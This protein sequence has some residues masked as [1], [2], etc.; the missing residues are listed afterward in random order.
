MRRISL[1]ACALALAVCLLPSTAFADAKNVSSPTVYGP[2]EGGLQ[3]YAWNHS[4][5]PLKAKGYDYTEQEFFYSG[6]AEDLSTGLNAP[7]ESRMLVRLPR[8]PKKFS[9]L[10]VVEWLNVTGQSDLETVWPIE[11]QFLMKHGIGYVGV[12]AQEAGICCGPTT[13]KGWD[14]R[15]YG[16]LI[17]PEDTFSYDIFSQA[18]KALREPAHNGTTSL[19]PTPPDPMRGMKIRKLVAT[20]A[21]QSSLYLTTFVNDHYNRGLIDLYVITRGGGPYDDFTTPIF[22]LNEEN[23]FAEQADNPHYV[24]WQEAGTAHAPA[25]WWGYISDEQQRDL[26]V[27][28]TADAIN[29]ACSV[30]HGSVDYSSRAFST[31]VS[32][33]FLGGKLPPSVPRVKTDASG[34]IARD[35]NG[36]AE[37]GLR[38]P[39][40]QV[41]VGFNTSDGCPLYGTYTPWSA[42]KIKS[43]YPTHKDYLK[44]LKAAADGDVKAGTLL[45]EDRD[46]VLRKAKAFTA[47]W[48]GGGSGSC[49]APR[50]LNR[51]AGRGGGPA[52]G[53]ARPRHSA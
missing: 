53:G 30:N 5:I 11:A 45:A 1:L 36:L 29:T 27:P 37:G 20:G 8:N 25:A 47:P 3:G 32:R 46:Q 9:G 23:S 21:A 50:G 24:V 6:N 4:L 35:A 18:L 51:A 38:Q 28:G 40:I 26:L 34:N 16:A 33:F 2:I 52:R 42:A 15:R 43:L 12:S 41:P 31:A 14:P 48:D 19:H 22:Q 17:H 44:R 7:Y 10:V 49:R 13:L 39:F